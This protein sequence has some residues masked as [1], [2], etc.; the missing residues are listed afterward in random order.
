MVMDAKVSSG[1]QS[2]TDHKER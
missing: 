2:M 1:Y